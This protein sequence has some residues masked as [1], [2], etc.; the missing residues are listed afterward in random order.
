VNSNVSNAQML[1]LLNKLAH[2]DL[3]RIRFE[4][5]PRTV[6]LEAGFGAADA[7]NFPVAQ[8]VPGALADKSAFAAAHACIG[9][10]IVATHACMQLPGPGLT[11]SPR[12][13]A[14]AML[15]RAA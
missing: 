15:E 4:R 6:L 8:L 2:D 13:K 7:A 14:A 1:R 9:Q 3:F 10:A 11:A 12:P 5:Q